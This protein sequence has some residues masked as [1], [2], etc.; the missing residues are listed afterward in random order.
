MIDHLIGMYVPAAKP[1]SA[2]HGI[3]SVQLLARAY[4]S[5][6]KIA[7]DVPTTCN[8]LRP[9]R[10]DSKPPGICIAAPTALETAKTKPSSVIEAPRKP[11]KI[12]Q[13]GLI[14]SIA[15]EFTRKR[16]ERIKISLP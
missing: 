16:T 3:K 12:G 9:Y 13:I 4:I 15:S 5:G 10:S 14:N 2:I 7:N 8:R 1:A 11:M 6:G